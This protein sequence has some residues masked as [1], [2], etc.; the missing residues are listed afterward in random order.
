MK[1]E[2]ELA[3][4]LRDIPLFEGLSDRELRDVVKHGAVVDHKDGHEVV[5]EGRETAVGFHLILDGHAN[6]LQGGDVRSQLGPGDYFGEIAL[7]DGK[8]RSATVRAA[9]G[10][11]RTFSVLAWEF[12]PLLD[13]HPQLSYKLLIGLCAHVRAMES[14]AEAGQVQSPSIR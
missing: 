4:S 14:G 13:A 6:V 1:H 11:L 10:A 2:S 8:P 12:K 7:L 5:Q 9:G 3:D